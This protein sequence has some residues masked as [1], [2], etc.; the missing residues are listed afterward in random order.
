MKVTSK[1]QIFKLI[2]QNIKF[3]IDDWISTSSSGSIRRHYNICTNDSK[4]IENHRLNDQKQ[5]ICSS[6][7]QPIIMI[8]DDDDD[9][10]KR[11][12]C[13]ASRNTGHSKGK[14]LV[15]S[16]QYVRSDMFNTN[17][18]NSFEKKSDVKKRPIFRNSFPSNC[19]NSSTLH[20]S[21][22]NG[23]S[24]NESPHIYNLTKDDKVFK[25]TMR[26][27]Y[28]TALEQSIRLDEKRKY[29][30]MLNKTILSPFDSF[31]EYGTPIGKILPSCSS[32]KNRG[33]RCV[34]LATGTKP[35]TIGFVDLTKPRLSTRETIAKVLD[36][37]DNDVVEVKDNDSDVEILPDP[38]SPKP[39]IKVE[40]VNSL[41]TYINLS[42]ATK[43]D[44]ISNM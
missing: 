15:P 40:R 7:N 28:S 12:R 44:W 30:E 34:E 11:N 20:K 42:E 21:I 43:D 9:F 4:M 23:N 24:S 2:C 26:R 31:L 37:F 14:F 33:R 22:T 1:H 17:S 41:K 16:Q 25:P 29:Q 19:Y 10:I 6:K 39:D 8:D 27:T 3:F 38:P 5:K 18:F 32:T 36:S 35:K 13:L